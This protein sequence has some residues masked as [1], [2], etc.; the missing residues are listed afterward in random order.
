MRTWRSLN[1]RPALLGVVG[2][3]VVAG[4]ALGLPSQARARLFQFTVPTPTPRFSPPPPTRTP[5]P[6]GQ[7]TETPL[8][9]GETVTPGAPATPLAEVALV[10][11][12]TISRQD[13][14][15]GDEVRFSFLL[16]NPSAEAATGLVFSNS[17]DPAL[18]L[19]KISA[20]QGSARVQ[21][22]SVLL[23]LGAVESRASA[24]ILLD[25]RVRPE[26]KAGQIILNAATVTFDQGQVS[27]NTV[28]A[29]LPPDRLPATGA[30]RRGP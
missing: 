10:F 1:W 12:Q 25:A 21:G 17:L 28:A 22:Q 7:P 15:P 20:T 9:P 5:G 23:S 3:A 2:L 13:V 14:L 24:L 19:L 29:G 6:P 27:S 4:L 30:D 26:S 16:S 18:E 8:V 11:T